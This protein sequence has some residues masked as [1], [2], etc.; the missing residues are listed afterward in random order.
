MILS[1]VNI[2]MLLGGGDSHTPSG[3]PINY[4]SSNPSAVEVVA[5]RPKLKLGVVEH[6]RLHSVDATT[7]Y[8]TM[9]PDL[10]YK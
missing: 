10:Q 3:L 9:H 2:S 4:V 6:P 5:E 8:N 7:R 1:S